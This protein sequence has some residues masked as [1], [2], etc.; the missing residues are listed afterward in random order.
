MSSWSRSYVWRKYVSV[1]AAIGWPDSI[2]H[3]LC[4]GRDG[5]STRCAERGVPSESGSPWLTNRLVG[6]DCRTLARRCQTATR[7]CV[8]AARR[9][10]GLAPRPHGRS[11]APGK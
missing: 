5:G 1:L 4:H 2:S 8:G 3:L 9:P 11:D 7:P 10:E 6:T